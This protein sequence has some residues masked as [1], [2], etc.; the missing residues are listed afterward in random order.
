MIIP[1]QLVNPLREVVPLYGKEKSYLYKERPKWIHVN[2][3][4]ET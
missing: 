2:C 1:E 4:N 3:M